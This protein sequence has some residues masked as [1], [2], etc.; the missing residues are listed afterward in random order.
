MQDA[1]AIVRDLWDR[2]IVLAADLE[3][4]DWSRPTPC[5]EWDVHDLLAHLSGIQT[6]MDGAPQPPLPDGWEAPPGLAQLDTWTAAGVAARRAW[7]PAEII[8]E[9]NAA[10]DGH[11][12]RLA[13][14]D[15]WSTPTFGPTGPTTEELLLQVRMFDIWTHLQ[16]LR[17]ALDLPIDAGD[18]SPAARAAYDF[19]R[20]RLGWLLV[21]RVGA[22]EGAALHV[23]L[24]R[25]VDADGVVE[26]RDG[27]GRWSA[28]AQAGEDRV[29][30]D[31]A[32]F[33]LLCAGRGDPDGW[34]EQGLLSWDGELG[35]SFVRTARLF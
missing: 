18:P 20:D 31:P 11:V 28:D 9:L 1:P 29:E 7:E 30:A 25:P 4:P 22:S 24:G 34:R 33:T 35:E 13:A 27:R 16:D 15:D 12:A 32:A 23:R 19:V 14:V 21:K 26:V 3:E 17:L 10:R 5:Q 2:I 6:A 8:D